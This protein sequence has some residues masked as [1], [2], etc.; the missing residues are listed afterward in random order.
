MTIP[1]LVERWRERIEHYKSAQ[2]WASADAISK[3]MTE[4]EQALR[5]QSEN[6]ARQRAI[7]DALNDE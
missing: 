1:Q 2:G 3:C 4:L 6:E 7:D 5:E